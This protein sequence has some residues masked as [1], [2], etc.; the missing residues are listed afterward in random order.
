MASK[1]LRPA[2]MLSHS[3]YPNGIA[4]MLLGT[5][6]CVPVFS[7]LIILK[8]SKLRVLIQISYMFK[9]YIICSASSKYD[10]DAR[11]FT[12]IAYESSIGWA[13]QLVFPCVCHWP[14]SARRPASAQAGAPRDKL[15]S[16][17]K[18]LRGTTSPNCQKKEDQKQT[19]NKD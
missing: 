12:V 8:L 18:G 3:R 1:A 7:S 6:P 11:T 14:R 15:G 16:Q 9:T 10:R 17:G 2:Y 4:N 13:V 19:I 5:G